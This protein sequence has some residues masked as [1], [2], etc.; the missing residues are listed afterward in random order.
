MSG[1]LLGTGLD[2]SEDPPAASVGLAR[3]VAPVSVGVPVDTPALGEAVE[4][5]SKPD[6]S[7]GNLGGA[8]LLSL[9]LSVGNALSPV[10]V[11][12]G[13]FTSDASLESEDLPL[14]SSQ[15]RNYNHG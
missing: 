5:E 10:E 6:A 1:G 9:L 2:A 11:A 15:T 7:V 14:I 3:G 12:E 8:V 13:G 4:G